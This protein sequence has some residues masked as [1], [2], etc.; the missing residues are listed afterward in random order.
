MCV[1]KLFIHVT[2]ITVTINAYTFVQTKIYQ[3]HSLFKIQSCLGASAKRAREGL[4]MRA[5]QEAQVHC[6]LRYLTGTQGDL[7]E[8]RS[9]YVLLG[10][11]NPS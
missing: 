7:A 5:I 4:E 1:Y 2:E 8:A 10:V 9:L 11:L 6:K 3:E